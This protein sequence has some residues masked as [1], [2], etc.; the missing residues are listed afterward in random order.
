MHQ[1]VAKNDESDSEGGASSTGQTNDQ[2]CH[3][4]LVSTL[5]ATD[6]YGK[7]NS[8]GLFQLRLMA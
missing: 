7:V 3:R 8:P 1:L 5:L 2:D 6:N 4:I